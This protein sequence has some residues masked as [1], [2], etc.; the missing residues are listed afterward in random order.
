MGEDPFLRMKKEK[1]GGDRWYRVDK[2]MFKKEGK[3]GYVFFNMFIFPKDIF[4]EDES[5]RNLME[6]AKK[7]QN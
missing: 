2:E 4:E 5:I 7:E 3:P 6:W 1:E